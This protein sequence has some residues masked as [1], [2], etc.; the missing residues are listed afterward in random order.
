M[1]RNYLQL[2]TNIAS[3]F[4]S[5]YVYKPL[6]E[7]FVIFFCYKICIYEYT[8]KESTIQVLNSL[9]AMSQVRYAPLGYRLFVVL[10]YRSNFS[11]SSIY[12]EVS[13]FFQL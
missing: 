6:S 5:E 7:Y 4:Y 10:I 1:T 8:K 2:I 11:I 9:K 12:T 3:I 13:F